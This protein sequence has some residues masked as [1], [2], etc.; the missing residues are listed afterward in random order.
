MFLL[1]HIYVMCWR[2]CS[3]FQAVMSMS[4]NMFFLWL[5]ICLQ[6]FFMATNMSTYMFF[7]FD[8]RDEDKSLQCSS[9]IGIPLKEALFDKQVFQN[10]VISTSTSSTEINV[11]PSLRLSSMHPKGNS[12][13]GFI[14]QSRW[15]LHV[16]NPLY[17]LF[18]QLFHGDFFWAEGSW[19]F[20]IWVLINALDN[21]ITASKNYHIVSLPTPV[22]IYACVG[23]GQRIIIWIIW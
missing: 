7:M 5:Q 21:I 11:L 20:R 12:K 3:A 14:K 17:T 10:L 9:W 13:D 6:M 2:T 22:V 4:T 16:N 15:S 1:K 8:G 23:T 19:R 18:T